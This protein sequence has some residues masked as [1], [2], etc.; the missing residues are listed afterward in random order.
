MVVN[1]PTATSHGPARA[2]LAPLAAAI[3]AT[4]REEKKQSTGKANQ[5][6]VIENREREKCFLL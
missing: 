1:I 5:G 3:M 2:S 4:R 6:A